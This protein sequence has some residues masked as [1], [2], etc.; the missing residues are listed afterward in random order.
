MIIKNMMLRLYFNLLFVFSVP[1]VFAQTDSNEVSRHNIILDVL[2]NPMSL[3]RGFSYSAITSY[4]IQV[5]SLQS[6]LYLTLRVGFPRINT[7]IKADFENTY[8]I[9]GT[10]IQPGFTYY[11]KSPVQNKESF[12]IALLGYFS[13]SQHELEFPVVDNIWAV[14][15]IQKYNGRESLIGASFEW[16]SL[17][18]LYKSL[19][20]NA[21]LSIGVDEI[22]KNP[23]PKL[24]YD[25]YLNYTP[26]LGSNLGLIFGFKC[27]VHYLF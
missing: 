12:Y 17:F 3:D 9:K 22:I 10:F 11:F 16:G 15:K 7:S 13:N 19:K 27:G 14:N 8:R 1:N 18:A 6:K 23:F 25:G 20:M 2:F 24:K 4:G 26:G 21:A 5:S